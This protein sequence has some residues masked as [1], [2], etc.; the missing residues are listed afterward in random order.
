MSRNNVCMYA[1]KKMRS[2]IHKNEKQ[3]EA[4]KESC[5]GVEEKE[6]VEVLNRRRNWK[7]EKD[8]EQKEVKK[9]Q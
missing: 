1:Q 3:K 9:N 7:S 4:G 2:Y 8:E 5:G 6:E